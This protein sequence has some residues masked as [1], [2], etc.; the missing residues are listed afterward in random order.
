MDQ[1]PDCLK[2]LIVIKFNK[3]RIKAKQSRAEQSKSKLN[4]IK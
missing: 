2:K 4:Q 3:I 1:I